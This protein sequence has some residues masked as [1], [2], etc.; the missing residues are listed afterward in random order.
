MDPLILSLI[1]FVAV[2]AMVTALAYV[3]TDMDSTKAEDRLGVLTGKKSA[4]GTASTSIIKEELV[5][6]GMGG[7][8]VLF[9]K[10]VKKLSNIRLFFE[11]ADSPIRVDTFFI[12]SMVCFG[13]GILV[14]WIGRSP[15]PLYPVSGLCV[16]SLPLCWLWFR[17]RSRLN[18]LPH[19]FR[20]HWN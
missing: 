14:A 19:N 4:T 13:V 18:K 5:R 9:N 20:M 17:R 10:L 1:V 11:Q 6:E 7:L 2:V 8:S 16:G 3:F 15:T 12:I